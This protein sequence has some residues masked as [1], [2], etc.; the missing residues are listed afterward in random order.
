MLGGGTAP[1]LLGSVLVRLP[2]V[3][4]EELT[5]TDPRKGLPDLVILILNIGIGQFLAE[6]H[7]GVFLRVLARDK[8]Q[9]QV[10][11]PGVEAKRVRLG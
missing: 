11:D 7:V 8:P 5:F 10:N 3:I 2:F 9:L 1:H 4:E 6:C